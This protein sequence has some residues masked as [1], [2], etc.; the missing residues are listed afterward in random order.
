MRALHQKIDAVP[1]RAGLWQTKNLFFKDQPDEKYIIHFRDPVEA[2]KSLWRDAELSPAMV[3]GPGK[4]YEDKTK[5]NRI[6]SEMW[7]CKW[8]H[9]CQVSLMPFLFDCFAN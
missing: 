9:V 5:K 3:F 6:F 4:F 7:Y 1:E 2:I 8:W